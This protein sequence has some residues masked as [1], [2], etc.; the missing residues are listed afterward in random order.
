MYITNWLTVFGIGLVLTF[1]GGCLGALQQCAPEQRLYYDCGQ[2]TPQTYQEFLKTA[3]SASIR[4]RYSITGIYGGITQDRLPADVAQGMGI[5]KPYDSTQLYSRVDILVEASG[6]V[7]TATSCD[8]T[9]GPWLV[10]T[11]GG[12]DG[13][14]A[15]PQCALDQCTLD[16]PSMC[17]GFSQRVYIK[18]STNP[19]RW[20][21][22]LRGGTSVDNVPYSQLVYQRPKVY[23]GSVNNVLNVGDDDDEGNTVYCFEDKQKGAP[24][25]YDKCECSATYV[26]S[27][28][29]CFVNPTICSDASS[30]NGGI[31]MEWASAHAY[32]PAQGLDFTCG[33]SPTPCTR[34][35]NN[36]LQGLWDRK[37]DPTHTTFTPYDVMSWYYSG[38]D[39]GCD[40]SQTISTPGSGCSFNCPEANKGNN[41]LCSDSYPFTD[42]S[43]NT[44]SSIVTQTINSQS[45]LCSVPQSLYQMQYNSVG[46]RGGRYQQSPTLYQE[47]GG[48]INDFQAKLKLEWRKPSASLPFQSGGR[49]YALTC[50]MCQS[51][52]T[53]CTSPF[54]NSKNPALHA[55]RYFL[56][57]MD[58]IC[59]MNELDPSGTKL[60]IQG[61][62]V[63]EVRGDDGRTVIQ[64]LAN[65]QLNQ[66]L[67]KYPDDTKTFRY[68]SDSQPS[69]YGVQ[70]QFPSDSGDTATPVLQN[71]YGIGWCNNNSAPYWDNKQ[72]QFP[73]L[74]RHSSS[75]LGCSPLQQNDGAKRLWF[76]LGQG[77]WNT[78]VKSDTCSERLWADTNMF[79]QNGGSDQRRMCTSTTAAWS[80]CRSL[81]AQTCTISTMFDQYDSDAAHWL[82]HQT[83]QQP[84]WSQYPASKYAPIEY[85]AQGP[86]IWA[87]ST[88]EAAG[89]FFQTSYNQAKAGVTPRQIL[90]SVYVAENQIGVVESA[91]FSV[92][93]SLNSQNTQLNDLCPIFDAPGQNI[94]VCDNFGGVSPTQQN[95]GYFTIGGDFSSIISAGAGTYVYRWDTSDCQGFGLAPQFYG[96]PAINSV[97]MQFQ[98]VVTSGQLSTQDNR[99]ALTNALQNVQFSGWGIPDTADDGTVYGVSTICTIYLQQRLGESG[100]FIGVANVQL[101]SCSSTRTTQRLQP[102]VVPSTS[103]TPL[104]TPSSTPAASQSHL[105]TPSGTPTISPSNQGTA[106]NTPTPHATPSSSPN[107]GVTQS[108]SPS[109]GINTPMPSPTPP[110]DCSC[111]NITCQI[112]FVQQNKLDNQLMYILTNSCVVFVIYAIIALIVFVVAVLLIVFCCKD[113]SHGIT[114]KDVLSD[115]PNSKVKDPY[116]T[117]PG[118]SSNKPKKD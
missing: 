41:G 69:Y 5:I 55:Y 11:S 71:A 73:W 104:P 99:N 66:L 12:I 102:S 42:S 50:G 93:L 34:G 110:A 68:G 3:A 17:R 24:S 20:H 6:V 14:T 56:W 72:L 109:P 43:N 13:S 30:G 100:T 59:E 28:A 83:N 92:T 45:L 97:S 116:P 29:G 75:C 61:S 118:G 58:P 54:D 113:G 88:P 89:L 26:C 101:P 79:S 95:C 1:L 32:T 62:V 47:V 117:P 18:L 67:Y 39:Q 19:M 21:T 27:T 96:S 85:D 82:R 114:M 65:V 44:V 10:T 105:G 16:S 108:P 111:W 91:P 8:I 103:N 112:D 33:N 49:Y 40:P 106:S 86:N 23:K 115:S 46:V 70:L 81:T 4:N 35:T 90:L 53:S 77:D 31:A 63:M 60:S 7:D 107:P 15:F 98:L 80:L 48:Q 94:P 36:P 57:D 74:Q 78:L 52:D 76:T 87:D 25:N 9:I 2:T 51:P 38:N 64:T 22:P 37:L 84:L